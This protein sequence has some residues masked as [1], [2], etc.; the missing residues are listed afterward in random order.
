M[1]LKVINKTEKGNKQYYCVEYKDSTYFVP[2]FKFQ[3]TSTT[4]DMLECIVIE[5]SGAIKIKQDLTP[6]LQEFYT[7]GNEY[8]FTVRNDFSRAGYYEISDD[9]GLYFHLN[10]RVNN[11]EINLY[12][13]QKIYCRINKLSGIKVDLVLVKNK[14]EQQNLKAKDETIYN[15]DFNSDN[16]TSYI[17]ESLYSDKP[18]PEWGIA[19]LFD[20]V[21]VNEGDYSHMVNHWLLNKIE[22]HTHEPMIY[23]ESVLSVLDEMLKLIKFVLEETDCLKTVDIQQRQILQNR[24]SIIGQHL[25]SYIKVVKIFIKGLEEEFTNKTL[26]NLHTSGYIFEAQKQLDLMMRI[27]SLRRDIMAKQMTRIFEIIHNEE[28]NFWRTEP[29]RKAFI[30]LLEI[31]ISEN[32]QQVDIATSSETLNVLPIIE[33]LSI[34]LLLAD[35]THD[36]DVFDYNLNKAMLYRYASYLTSSTPRSALQNAFHALMDIS[37]NKRE[38]TWKDTMQHDLL[39]SKISA[40]SNAYDNVQFSKIYQDNGLSLSITE[41]ALVLEPTRNMN[42]NKNVL[43]ADMLKWNNMQIHLDQDIKQPNPKKHNSLTEY[44]TFWKDIELAILEN[45]K[46]QQPKKKKYPPVQAEIYEIRVISYIQ[47]EGYF[48]C[49]IVNDDIEGSGYLAP[50]DIVGYNFT[51]HISLFRDSNGDQLILE[52]RVININTDGYCIFNMTK[53]I[54]EFMNEHCIQFSNTTPVLLTSVNRLGALGVS[55]NGVSVK[56]SNSENYPDISVGDVIMATNWEKDKALTFR[57]DIINDENPSGTNF[58]VEN[59]VHALL[60]LYSIDS[61]ADDDEYNYQVTQQDDSIDRVRIEE[62]MNIIDRVAV[63]ESDYITSYNYLAM[64]RIMSKL[65]DSKEREMFYDGWMKL[66]FILHYFALNG[67]VSSTDL[68]EFE[69]NNAHLFDHKSEIYKRYIQLKII[70]YKDKENS[71]EALWEQISSDDEI[72]RKLAENVLAYNLLAD[73]GVSVVRTQISEKI[74]DLLKVK[75]L[76]NDLSDFGSEDLHTEFKTSIVYPA[77]SM[78][79]NLPVQTA[80]I[81]KEICAMLNAEGGNI[82]IG[83]NDFGIGIGMETDLNYKDFNGVKDKYDNYIR[84]QI[85][86]TLGKDADAYINSSFLEKSG[87]TIYELSI[88][89]YPNVARYEGVIYERHGASKISLKDENESL[90]LARKNAINSKASAIKTTSIATSEVKHKEITTEKAETPKSSTIKSSTTKKHINTIACSVR[91]EETKYTFEEDTNNFERYIQFIGDN[92][93]LISE[94]YPEN[95]EDNIKLTLPI[96]NEDTDKYLVLAYENGTTCKMSISTLLKKVD[97]QLNAR[98]IDSKLMFA[99][100]ADKDD[101]LMTISTNKKGG[102]QV[103]FDTINNIKEINSMTDSGSTVTNVAVEKYIRYD[104]ITSAEKLLFREIIDTSLKQVGRPLYYND[105]DHVYVNL[106]KIKLLK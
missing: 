98:Y 104:L 103:R 87:R 15:D 9:Y 11:K 59:A 99:E 28:E 18:Q 40:Q 89:A 54:H 55:S 47:E 33:A 16:I 80:E 45:K 43:P 31:Y 3:E 73:S 63:L 106:K 64:A 23:D 101:A 7:V 70:S 5:S 105:N 24:L 36:S 19:E 32:K 57:A 100:I 82:Y 10:N 83:V 75:N 52:A 74:Q 46:E 8:P 60:G 69:N 53:L 71:R 58:T 30:S 37:N 50:K 81:M 97:F 20:L 86:N 96:S 78:I 90:F 102:Q 34:Q 77:N 42:K 12:I 39:A 94:F 72:S 85:R 84:N 48:Y 14:E 25:K 38:Y 6:L 62:L 22:Q 49:Q 17:I 41:G 66:I 68:L 2:L 91:R 92:Y 51:P 79:A 65:I 56:L 44:Q 61:Y 76:R 88:K 95:P 4:P 29:F 26:N 21:F 27:F 13:G 35:P 67:V 93:Q 1:K